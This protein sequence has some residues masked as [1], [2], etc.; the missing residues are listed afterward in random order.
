MIVDVVLLRRLLPL[1]VVL[2]VASCSEPW[3]AT[4][5]LAP[6]AAPSVA[7]SSPVV[8]RSAGP[9]APEAIEPASACAVIGVLITADRGDAAMGY[10]EMPLTI[11]N[12]GTE[13]YEMKGRPD[14]VVLD[15]DGRPLKVAVV[16]SRH[17]TAAPRKVV[18]KPGTS[19][20]SVL[21]WRNTVTNTSGGVDTGV[22][23]AVAVS[24]GGTRQLVTLQAPLDL[25]NT[26]RLEAS[27]WF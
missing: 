13:P 19:A 10:R 18:L 11:R 5:G 25:G 7:A 4:D 22:S 2:L 20:R 3:Q 9:T 26:G 12:C 24:T 23:L 14:I 1:L 15:G 27:A 8:P 21:S 16:A 6:L 17:Y